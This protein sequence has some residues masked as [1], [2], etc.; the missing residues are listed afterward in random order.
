MQKGKHVYVT[1]ES[2]TDEKVKYN[3]NDPTA[4]YIADKFVAGTGIILAEGTG[5]NEN[6][7]LISNSMDTSGFVPYTGATSNLNLGAYSISAKDAYFYSDSPSE[8]TMLSLVEI[9]T[10]I[11]L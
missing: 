6:K 9:L 4:G 10:R 11:F 5:E 3:A 7:L 8:T 2:G 1:D